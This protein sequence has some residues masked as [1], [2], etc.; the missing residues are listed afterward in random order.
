MLCSMNSGQSHL[1]DDTSCLTVC[2]RS[3]WPSMMRPALR[4]WVETSVTVM[5]PPMHCSHEPSSRPLEVLKASDMATLAPDLAILD[6]SLKTAAL[7][8]MRLIVAWLMTTSADRLV[9][10]SFSRSPLISS[11]SVSLNFEC[12]DTARATRRPGVEKSTPTILAG[13]E[14]SMA[15]NARLPVPMPRSTTTLPESGVTME[16]SGSAIGASRF[17]RS[18]AAASSWLLHWASYAAIVF[19]LM[20]LSPE[21]DGHL[22]SS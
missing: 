3:D 21:H 5:A 11:T 4:A 8:G 12:L 20:S 1:L 2:V 6:I 9:S 16:M 13:W 14:S 22:L 17:L 10:G 7:S 15:L 19:R 18:D